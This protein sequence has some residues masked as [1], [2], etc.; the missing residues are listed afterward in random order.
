MMSP[1]Y[2]AKIQLSTGFSCWEGRNIFNRYWNYFCTSLKFL[3]S[4]YLSKENLLF[5]KLT[6]VDPCIPWESC[7]SESDYVYMIFIFT[8]KQPSAL[9]EEF[10]LPVAQH[11]IPR[12]DVTHFP[13]SYLMATN[14]TFLFY[15]ETFAGSR[16]NILANSKFHE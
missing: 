4:S 14:V 3:K 9:E 8:K 13:L 16:Y 5:R 10:H 11:F 7:R 1:I 12:E 15:M 2:Q 6:Y